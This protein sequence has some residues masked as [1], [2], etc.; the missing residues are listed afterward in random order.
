MK[1]YT[2]DPQFDFQIIRFTSRLKHHPEVMAD[3]SE[4]GQAI[5]DFESWYTWWTSK[6]SYYEAQVNWILLRATFGQ[7][8][9][10]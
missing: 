10:T 3:L 5:T 7:Q 2:G 4:V 9:S 8:L 1:H 6:A